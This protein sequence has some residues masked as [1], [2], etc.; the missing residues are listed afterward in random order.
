MGA[1]SVAYVDHREL[2]RFMKEGFIALGV[3]GDDAALCARVLIESDLRGVESHGIGRF[4]MYVDRIR[5]GI[6]CPVTKTAIVRETT[7]TAVID[8]NHGMAVTSVQDAGGCINIGT[9]TT[10]VNVLP[11]PAKAATPSGPDFVNSDDN[12]TSVYTTSGATNADGY[13]WMVTPAGAYTN[14]AVSG[15]ELT[16]TWENTYNGDANIS[17]RGVNGNCPG[18][19]SDLLTVALE[20]AFGIDELAKALGLSVYPNPNK[21]S[22]TLVLSTDQVDKV[23]VNIVN[24]LGRVVYEQQD[25]R[26]NA[27]FS[28]NIDISGESEGIYLMIVKSDLGVHTSR[29]VLQ[30]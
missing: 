30:K 6:L 14:M 5:D 23:N 21:G 7:N 13:E 22:F 2:E 8:G 28:T 26:V 15:M 18:E 29:I 20:S 11:D 12:P 1:S 25:L 9:G 19:F 24:A 4:K 16:I 10:Q 17:V 27:N 3:P